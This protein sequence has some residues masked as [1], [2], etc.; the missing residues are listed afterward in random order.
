MFYFCFIPVICL[1]ILLLFTFGWPTFVFPFLIFMFVYFGGYVVW[2]SW[3]DWWLADFFVGKQV[4]RLASWHEAMQRRHGKATQRNANQ[5]KAKPTQAKPIH[6]QARAKPEP[7]QSIDRT[8]NHQRKRQEKRQNPWNQV[9]SQG[10]ACGR[11]QERQASPQNAD[12][13][14]PS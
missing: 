10:I 13:T 14:A 12:S 6:S 7:S 11:W 1:H 4:G 2:L 9:W 8:K 5:S 3:V